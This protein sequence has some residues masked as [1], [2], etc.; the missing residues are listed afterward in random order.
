MITRI[1]VIKIKARTLLLTCLL[2]LSGLAD[3]SV[4]MIGTRIVY[5]GGSSSVNVEFANKDTIPYAVQVWVDSGDEESTPATARAP[6]IAAPALFRIMPG[7]GQVLRL[8]YSGT[9]NLPQDRESI[10]YLNF[11]QIPPANLDKDNEQ[12]SNKM[13]VMLKNRLKI[14]YRPQT[15]TKNIKNI[16]DDIHVVSMQH[17]NKTTVKINNE[18]PF[19]FSLVNVKISAAGKEFNHNADMLSPFSHTEVTFEKLSPM[20]KYNVVL[21]F[22]NDQGAY[23]NHG[24]E[25]IN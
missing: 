20:K 7:S 23:V 15:I 18:S 12:K 19:Y 8:A 24:Y 25:I 4:T 5:P 16:T 11:L 17:A 3:A 21:T 10:Y 13:L 14:F 9:E 22:I 1:P 6:F 2:L